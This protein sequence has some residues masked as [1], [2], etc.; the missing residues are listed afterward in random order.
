MGQI[1]YGFRTVSFE[2]KPQDMC[3]HISAFRISGNVNNIGGFFKGTD[4]FE[5]L[6]DRLQEASRQERLQELL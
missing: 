3:D 4:G 2:D 6:I 5:K 1:A